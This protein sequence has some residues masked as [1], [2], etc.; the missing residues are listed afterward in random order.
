MSFHSQS[1]L[2]MKLVFLWTK[3]IQHARCDSRKS[4]E[5]IN[6]I[7]D[8]SPY[9]YYLRTYILAPDVEWSEGDLLVLASGFAA[10]SNTA[11]GTGLRVIRGL[12]THLPS[13][14]AS[15]LP[16]EDDR[17]SPGTAWKFVQLGRRER[18]AL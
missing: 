9:V 11:L 14:H 5:P 4:S 10:S 1:G 17:K 15:I 12:R 13:I 18:H 6:T 7:H 2:K 3:S 8:A 16:S